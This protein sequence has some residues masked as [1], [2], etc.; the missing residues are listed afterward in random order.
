MSYNLSSQ[1]ANV[2]EQ[3]QQLSQHGYGAGIGETM[4]YRRSFI[5]CVRRYFAGVTILFSLTSLFGGIEICAAQ[6]PKTQGSDQGSRTS[7]ADTA[8]QAVIH[9][10]SNHLV[11]GAVYSVDA[12]IK[13][14][15]P[16]AIRIDL[17]SIQLAV[18]PELGPSGF[19]CVYF[20][21][22]HW[23]RSVQPNRDSTILILQPN[24]Q[25]PVFFNLGG[26]ASDAFARMHDSACTGLSWMGKL[27]KVLDFVPGDY[28][29]VLTANFSSP[30]ASMAEANPSQPD[31]WSAERQFSQ[32][33]QLEV[34][35][36]QADTLLFAALG[37]IFAYLLMALQAQGD[38]AAFAGKA[39]WTKGWL[40]QAG[41]VVRNAIG[42]ALLSA[43]VT[44]VASR[45]SDTQF[46]VKVSVGDFW[47]A[48]TIGFVSYFIGLKFIDKLSGLIK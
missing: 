5:E 44:V 39:A 42:A 45:L 17:A 3:P 18:Q 48:L 32:S 31:T 33:A 21:L 22:T 8:L 43:A 12:D 2:A 34:G 11:K 9:S 40:K 29:F 46:P 10:S 25:F 26:D 30:Q 6:M 4:V 41:L 24:D 19:R 20:P 47:G 27:R 36:D 28:S 16:L 15:S 23:P 13:N 1:V 37:G 35:V 14:V 38:M 7:E